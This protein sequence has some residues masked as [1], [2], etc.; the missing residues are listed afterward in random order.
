MKKMSSLVLAGSLALIL[1]ACGG[2]QAEQP[3]AQNQPA[4]D[5]P[6]QQQ[7]AAGGGTATYDAAAAEAKYQ[8]NC[9]GCHGKDLQGQV[10]PK[11]S[12]IGARLS[13]EQI[14]EVINKGK[15]Q[16]PPALVSGT[17]AE[18]VAAWLADKK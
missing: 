10:G 5:Q 14:L 9:M 18:N 6:A 13:R 2:Q 8:Q 1:T 12:D 3:P 4:Q 16:M 7:P 17:D 11:L 15:G